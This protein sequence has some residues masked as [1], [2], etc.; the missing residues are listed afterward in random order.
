[1][2]ILSIQ[3][4]V[5]YGHVGNAA[6]LF[7]LQRLGAE[8]LAVHTLQFSNHPGYGRFRGMR[9]PPSHVA[10]VIT[11]L[12]E[13]GILAACHGVLSGYLAEAGTGAA[14]L[15]AVAEMRA[16]NPHGLYCCDPVFGDDG[17]GVY[18]HPDLPR[19]FLEE[20]LPAA[21][22]ATPNRFELAHL[23]DI[24]CRTLTEVK[25]AIAALQ[26]KMRKD[27]LQ[28]VL[29][30]SLNTESTPEDA[31]DTIVGESSAFYLLRTPKLPLRPSGSG[32]LLA[33]LFFYHCLRGNS[34]REALE[35]AVSALFGILR[36]TA[37]LGQQELAIIAAQD[38]VITP[39]LRFRAEP[40]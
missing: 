16:A 20:A 23:T 38:E 36:R 37:E 11:G 8:V 5:A 30:S 33:A 17:P 21:D 27:G 6:A 13:R 19:F 7:P 32:D 35:N 25:T 18:V 1:M 28:T 2:R 26:G 29:V 34:G 9:F 40:V 4:W 31:I 3:S 14:V 15:K 22:I 10:D 39:S 24:P 12:A